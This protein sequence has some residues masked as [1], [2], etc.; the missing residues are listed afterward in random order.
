MQTPNFKQVPQVNSFICDRRQYPIRYE[1]FT[2]KDGTR[3]TF[4]NHTIVRRIL[5]HLLL[6]DESKIL[7]FFLIKIVS[8]SHRKDQ[9]KH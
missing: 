2:S 1:G 8:K 7:L 5:G 6:A 3:F 9:N 4:E